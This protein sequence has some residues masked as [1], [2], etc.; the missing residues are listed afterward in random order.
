MKHFSQCHCL[1][2]KKKLD[3]D[4]LTL[5]HK[6]FKDNK[7]MKMVPNDVIRLQKRHVRRST[8]VLAKAFYDDPLFV[9]F[10]SDPTKRIKQ[11]VGLLQ[12]LIRYGILYGEPEAT[13]SSL[14]GIAVWLPSEK[15]DMSPWGML[16]SGAISSVFRVGM[17][18]VGRMMH[19]S[20]HADTI[21]KR[22]APFR[23]WFLQ[24]IGVD[25]S[26]QGRGYASTLLRSRV[27]RL[28]HEGLPCYLDTQTEKSVLIYEH[29]GFK[30]VEEFYVPNTSFNNWAMLRQPLQ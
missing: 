30:V 4:R 18:A 24:P 17:T 14:E 6:Y 25:P 26:H 1:N 20:N 27:E 23:H 15:A 5:S 7:S 12:L 22:H 21:H 10:F 19:F 29:Y 13:S 9:Y 2:N 11:S 3:Y 8:E 16:R 28:D